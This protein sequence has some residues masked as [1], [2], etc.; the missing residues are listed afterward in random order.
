MSFT[1]QAEEGIVTFPELDAELEYIPEVLAAFKNGDATAYKAC[2]TIKSEN[3]TILQHANVEK[4][5]QKKKDLSKTEATA[6]N[7]PKIAVDT[8]NQVTAKVAPKMRSIA[9]MYRARY[10]SLTA[11]EKTFFNKYRREHKKQAVEKAKAAKPKSTAKAAVKAAVPSPKT[12]NTTKEPK[13]LE[14]SQPK[15][16]LKKEKFEDL[17]ISTENNNNFM[18]NNHLDAETAKALLD[19][20]NAEIAERKQ[21][22]KQ[23]LYCPNSK[24]QEIQSFCTKLDWNPTFAEGKLNPH[25]KGACVREVATKIAFEHCAINKSVFSIYGSA[26]DA[27]YAEIAGIDS[28]DV[29]HFGLFIDRS[30]KFDPKDNKRYQDAIGQGLTVYDKIKAEYTDYFLMNVYANRDK[31]LISLIDTLMTLNKTVYWGGYLFPQNARAGFSNEEEAV[32]EINDDIVSYYA[33]TTNTYTHNNVYMEIIESKI[34]FQVL[35]SFENFYLLRFDMKVRPCNFKLYEKNTLLIE[36]QFPA[37]MKIPF[38]ERYIQLPYSTTGLV[39]QNVECIGQLTKTTTSN[40]VCANFTSNLLIDT[41]FVALKNRVVNYD[42][43]D[44]VQSTY[45]YHV[46]KYISLNSLLYSSF[47][48]TTAEDRLNVSSLSSYPTTR[49]INLWSICKKIGSAGIFLYC[50]Y[51]V[52]KHKTNSN[53]VGCVFGDTRKFT[54]TVLSLLQL[55][56]FLKNNFKTWEKAR[57]K[58]QNNKNSWLS[59]GLKS[60]A[61]TASLGAMGYIA[62]KTTNVNVLTSA[63]AAGQS[64]SAAFDNGF[65]DLQSVVAKA[66]ANCDL[67]T[68]HIVKKFFKPL[69]VTTT[70]NKT[71]LVACVISPIVE[72]ALKAIFGK[73]SMSLAI[74]CAEASG[75]RIFRQYLFHF[76][77]ASFPTFCG[78]PVIGTVAHGLWNYT[79]M[80]TSACILDEL[81]LHGVENV[82]KVVIPGYLSAPSSWLLLFSALGCMYYSCKNLTYYSSEMESYKDHYYVMKNIEGYEFTSVQRYEF[83]QSFVPRVLPNKTKNFCFNDKLI[84]SFANK[85]TATT[86]LDFVLNSFIRDGS[87]PFYEDKLQNIQLLL[88]FSSVPVYSLLSCDYSSILLMKARSLN[89]NPIMVNSN[90][91]DWFKRFSCPFMVRLYKDLNEDVIDSWIEGIDES[92]KKKR[93]IN[94][95]VRAYQNGFS[96]PKPITFLA[97]LDEKFLVP[98]VGREIKNVDPDVALQT[99][100]IYSTAMK[101][102]VKYLQCN[103]ID[104]SLLLKRSVSNLAIAEIACGYQ[105]EE[106]DAW[107]KRTVCSSLNSVIVQG[108]DSL[109]SQIYNKKRF[110]IECDFSSYDTCQ[111]V[112]VL[113]MCRRFDI[114]MGID[115]YVA[116]LMYQTHYSKIVLKHKDSKRTDHLSRKNLEINRTLAPRRDSGGANTSYHNSIVNLVIWLFCFTNKVS[117]FDLKTTIE[118]H[119]GFECKIKISEDVR[120]V[121]FLKGKFWPCKSGLHYGPLPSRILKCCSSLKPTIDVYPHVRKDK[122]NVTAEMFLFGQARVLEEL[123]QI[124]II[125]SFV[126]RFS[127]KYTKEEVVKTEHLFYTYSPGNAREEIEEDECFDDMYKRYNLSKEE[128]ISMEKLLCNVAVFSTLP[129]AWEKLLVDY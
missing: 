72:E 80:R 90:Q 124:P 93:A 97:K 121:T 24:R 103:L 117:P 89:L 52:Y 32:W 108:D 74:A 88:V 94:A 64:I 126:K 75:P 110:F 21:R 18:N 53:S 5:T 73:E 125:R 51:Q 28:K 112:E 7:D 115:P 82:E 83:E 35:F 40:M 54:M 47:I 34:P 43:L 71:L 65:A 36:A 11:E 25:W 70:D 102:L 114:L 15:M 41:K 26:R 45:I 44:S 62:Y 63:S 120:D 14:K 84:V 46:S 6:P 122:W 12:S 57:L 10:S 95:K 69:E 61:I 56:V 19:L 42:L 16:T 55:R 23:I 99:C 107:Y 67:S 30:A 37:T 79:V 49:S 33:D 100:P 13:K 129:G 123:L 81:R 101:D 2:A 91:K 119:L 59:Y 68:L 77:M 127:G 85:S 116:N 92:R 96:G 118:T 58:K 105:A 76:V 104:T 31:S 111:D 9:E 4:I 113:D 20:A 38:T 98:F 27:K 8:S 29:K 22:P 106:I 3:G 60:L 109:V 48:P 1:Y 17:P 50:L 66:G 87:G 86:D 39:I 128:I 78:I